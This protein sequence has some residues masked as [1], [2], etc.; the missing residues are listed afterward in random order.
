M[1]CTCGQEFDL[2]DAG[3]V[4]PKCGVINVEIN[5]EAVAFGQDHFS[6]LTTLSDGVETGFS[7]S[8]RDGI[9]TEATVHEDGTISIRVTGRSPQGE[10]DTLQACRLLI[11]GLNDAGES[12]SPPKPGLG[13]VDAESF[14]TRDSNRHLRMQVVHAITDSSFWRGLSHS[15]EATFTGNPAEVAGMIKDAILLKANHFGNAPAQRN[16]TLVIDATRLPGLAFSTVASAFQ[17]AHAAWLGTLGFEA[18][19]VVGPHPVPPKKL[20]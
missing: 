17:A 15:G 9:E 12:W 2:S 6:A 11:N 18:I 3:G 7:E 1:L 5:D 8:E 20:L 16:I 10:S 14:D 19:W 13:A 4:C